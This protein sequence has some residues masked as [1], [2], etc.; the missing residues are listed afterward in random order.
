[1]ALVIDRLSVVS[2]GGA[3][4]YHMTTTVQHTAK[5]LLALGILLL[6]GCGGPERQP[7]PPAS[8]PTAEPTAVAPT[9]TPNLEAT[10]A[11]LV[12]TALPATAIPTATPDIPATVSA[13]LTRLAPPTPAAEPAAPESGGAPATRPVSDIVKSVEGGLAQIIMPG[14]GGSG[15]V[16]AAD[17]LIVTNAHV[18]GRAASATVRLVNGATYTGAVQGRDE[19]LDLAVIKIDAAP[20]LQPIP[21]GN[22]AHVRAGDAVIALGFPLGDE[23]GQDYT[24][25]T[26]V[27]SSRRTYGGVE[28]IQTDAALNPGNSGGPLL[29]RDGAVIGVNTASYSGTYDGISFALSVSAVQENLDT[30]AAGG[31]VLADAGGEWWTHANAECDYSVRVHPLWTLVAETDVCDAH[32]ERYDGG[33]LVG[34]LGIWV[35]DL[36]PGQTL[37]DFAQW[38]RDELITLARDRNWE[39]YQPVSF[40]YDSIQDRYV[41]RYLWRDYAEYCIS[42]GV[43]FI[44]QSSRRNSAL[45]IN[46][47][48]CAFMPQSVFDEISQMEFSY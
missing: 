14:G 35:Y 4:C 40:E 19:R 2:P 20:A 39:T 26:G 48:I 43:D 42:S 47:S 9:A 22:P 25:T 10:V 11:A 30:L 21:L 34:T 12:A 18:V 29:N 33:D 23:L 5:L 38:R 16:V 6:A 31:S 3:R 28:H 8:I 13:E 32:F 27:V 44:V 36:E 46:N 41:I 24:V 45:I 7:P 37:S 15:F 17:G 1:M